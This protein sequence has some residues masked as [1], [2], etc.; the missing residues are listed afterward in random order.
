MSYNILRLNISYNRIIK[1]ISLKVKFWA[2][3]K[4]QD[5]VYNKHFALVRLLD[6]IEVLSIHI[7]W[8]RS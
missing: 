2:K 5:W 4:W 1:M 6:A 3:Y 8:G 7:C